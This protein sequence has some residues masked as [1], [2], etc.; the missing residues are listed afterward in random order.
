[1]KAIKVN[2]QIN[3]VTMR[4]DDSVSFSATTPELSDIELGAFRQLQKVEVVALLEA[5]DG[6]TEVMEVKADLGDKT[7]AQRLRGVLYRLWEAKPEG[8]EFEVYYRVKM[9]KLIDAYKEKLGELTT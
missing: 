1:M 8:M 7:P 4:K 5:I 2:L 9:E 6:S 3:R